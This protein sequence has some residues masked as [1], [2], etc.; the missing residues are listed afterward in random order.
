[1]NEETTGNDSQRTDDESDTQHP[2]TV[3]LTLW[4]ALVTLRALSGHKSEAEKHDHF[5]MGEQYQKAGAKVR[6]EL[7]DALERGWFP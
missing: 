7:N 4:E 3:E 6:G 1:M 5:G 2:V